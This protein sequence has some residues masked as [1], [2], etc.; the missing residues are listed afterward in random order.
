[1]SPIASQLEHSVEVAVSRAFAWTYRTDVT[2]WDDPPAQ[3]ALAGPFEQGSSGTTQFPG[4]EPIPWHIAAVHPGRSFVLEMPLDGATLAFEWHFDSISEERTK[5][6]QRIILSGD[7]AKAYAARVEAGFGPT[8][9]DGMRR[10]AALME[11]AAK[12]YER[13]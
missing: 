4:Q 13:S 5:L 8:L 10:V 7:N 12:N 11:A 2:T 9:V 6:T 3:F 1:M